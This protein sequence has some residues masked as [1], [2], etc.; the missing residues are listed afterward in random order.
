MVGNVDLM[1]AMVL[2]QPLPVTDRP[3][4]LTDLP[5]PGPAPGTILVKVT[6]CAVCHTDLHL[7]EGEL[8]ALKLP[9]IPGHQVVGVV[10]AVGEG[11][12]GFAPGDRVG[13]P[14][15]YSTCSRCDFCR[16]GEENLCLEARFTGYHVDGGYADYMVARADFAARIP[17]RF[18]DTEAAPLLCA[19][20]IGYRSLRLATVQPGGRV[21]LFGFGASAHLALQ[22]ARHWGC[23]VYVF[24]RSPAHR[25]LAA[26]LGATWVGGSED[27]PPRPLDSAVVFAPSGHVVIDALRAL[28][29]GGTVAV[30]AIH[31]DR[32]PEF[33][34][35]V[36]YWERTLRS[37][38]NS[39]R[40][41]AHEFLQL[42]A[43]I[44][45]RVETVTY[46]LEAANDALQA[47]KRS[48]I[49]GAAVLEIG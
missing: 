21:G 19:G 22:M 23:E 29:R 9:I 38:S 41:D 20:I 12:V 44:P 11:V 16:R 45:L 47:L 18:G 13:V 48:E 49:S 46:P 31:L 34:Y 28:R 10:D 24:S 17:A 2:R 14:W 15:L 39:T 7:V 40:R 32:I 25:R 26:T 4:E 43:A 8:S 33:D 6:R 1:R 27:R 35:E 3:L 5:V 30:N 42:A 37:V 36:L